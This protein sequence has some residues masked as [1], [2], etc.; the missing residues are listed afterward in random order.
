M[1]DQEKC[2]VCNKKR[3]EKEF[4]RPCGVR[5]SACCWCRRGIKKP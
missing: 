4:M 3:S 5:A 2:P 1:A